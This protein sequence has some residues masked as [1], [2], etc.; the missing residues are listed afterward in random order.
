VRP[1]GW[2]GA[3][4]L[5]L[6]L[7]AGAR[8][9]A[10]PLVLGE[11]ESYD[12]A[13]YLEVLE[14]PSG[15]L[16][17]AEVQEA[18]RRGEF[19]PLKGAFAAGYSRSAYWLRFELLRGRGF[20]ASCLL[21]F[22]PPSIEQVTLYLPGA[23]PLHLGSA[24]R[25]AA[26]AL[27][28]PALVAPVE[29]PPLA[30]VAVYLRLAGINTIALQ[31]S[32]YTS[33]A[34][35]SSTDRYIVWLSV[36]F[37][38]TLILFL[39]S[40]ILFF[41]S[42]SRY[43]LFFALYV[44]SIYLSLVIITGMDAFFFPDWLRPY[45]ALMLRASLGFLLLAFTL[46]I[47][48]LFQEKMTALVWRYFRLLAFL[49][50]LTLAAS[51]FVFFGSV[52]SVV[53]M[54][55]VGAIPVL[56]WLSFRMMPSVL[57]GLVSAF[58]WLLNMSGYFVYYL[59]LI[60]IIAD[61][62]IATYAVEA[63]MMLHAFSILPAL[64]VR[65]W[66]SE[67]RRAEDTKM[68]ALEAE[69]LAEKIRKEL[70]ICN[71]RLEVSLA[72]ERSAT[73]R[74]E[75]FLSIVSHDYRA[76]LAVIKGNV[77]LI[78][79]VEREE[80][81]SEDPSVIKIQRAVKRLNELMDVSLAKSRLLRDDDPGHATELEVRQLVQEQ[82]AAVRLLWPD[83]TIDIEMG[84]NHDEPSPVAGLFDIVLYNLLDNALKYSPQDTSVTVSCA[85]RDRVVALC[86]SNVTLSDF[87]EQSERLFE[88]FIRGGN[89]VGSAG[90]GL[91]LWVVQQ[92]VERHGGQ[93]F[94]KRLKNRKV[95]VD[96][97]LPLSS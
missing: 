43:F 20:P 55:F 53:M 65:L 21:Q 72:A 26:Q 34:L 88:Q 7:L 28:Y 46:F 56:V 68:T 81:R 96:V 31:G 83:R 15:V 66:Q 80:G 89:A 51:P 36:F 24:D 61:S 77:D 75:T 3:L 86:V 50:L 63:S 59:H 64:V 52:A 6:L 30:P 49:A 40:L 39:V 33:T 9:Q 92:I 67:R 76:P 44:L 41:S 35:S 29:L 74:I 25:I 18:A 37:G 82:V 71:A 85:V 17:V 95:I 11:E 84:V 47:A 38:A 4:L 58:V 27:M 2:R 97:L 78:S 48:E 91:G 94:M 22:L 70:S 14:D 10:V 32:V 54:I 60:G 1:G 5:L 45:S 73:Q 62:I 8:V 12:L 93:V 23:S 19:R 79:R 13:G 69:A 87:H 16:G 42:R 90:A 57:S